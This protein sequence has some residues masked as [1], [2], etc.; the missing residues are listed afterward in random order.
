MEAQTLEKIE[1]DL[2]EKYANPSGLCLCGCGQ[3]VSLSPVNR[4]KSGRVRDTPLRYIHGHSPR[5]SRYRMEPPNPSGRCM[6]GCGQLTSISRITIVAEGKVQGE[7]IRYLR[8]HNP[9]R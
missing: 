9:K 8:G 5:V 1:D 7:H 4:P 2:S 6:C 3:P